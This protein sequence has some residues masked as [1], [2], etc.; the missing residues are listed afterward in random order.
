MGLEAR[1][2]CLNQGCNQW[3]FSNLEMN[4]HGLLTFA[5]SNLSATKMMWQHP[6]CFIANGPLLQLI[7]H[8]CLGTVWRRLILLAQ[9]CD[10]T[11]HKIYVWTVRLQ[12]FST[13]PYALEFSNMG[14]VILFLQN[15]EWKLLKVI[16]EVWKV[17]VVQ[18]LYF[19]QFKKILQRVCFILK[20]LDMFLPITEQ[21]S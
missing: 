21:M 10:R 16:A 13:C 4:L 12:P 8:P 20:W 17:P 18:S 7:P 15:V 3:L 9:S 5:Q 14:V 19:L 11:M 1:S 6:R 2:L